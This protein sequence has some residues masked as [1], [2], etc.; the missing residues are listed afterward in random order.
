MTTQ[1][2]Y[3]NS[4]TQY[5]EDSRHIAWKSDIGDLNV[6][7]P[8]NL[9]KLSTEKNLLH[10]SNAT[11]GD[12]RMKTWY[13][14]T[15]NYQIVDVP[16]VITGIE[17]ALKLKR[18]RIVE[19]TIQLIFTGNTI[20]DN[21]VYYSQDIENHIKIIPNPTYGGET[22]LWGLSSISA[23]TVQDSSFGI[24]LRMMS[25]PYYPHNESPFLEY[26]AIRVHG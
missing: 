17:V 21:Q 18:S 26:V 14:D 13:L 3:P 5:A 19:E 6:L 25:H 24:R 9:Y 7:N 2:F 4:V 12:I 1:W 10:I 23:L 8:S 11:A 16:E 22:K 20:G 15:T